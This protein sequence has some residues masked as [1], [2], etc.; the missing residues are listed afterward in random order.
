MSAVHVCSRPGKL[1]ATPN[2]IVLVWYLKRTNMKS[3]SPSTSCE[4]HRVCCESDPPAHLTKDG[5]NRLQYK[6]SVAPPVGQASLPVAQA[7]Q[8]VEAEGDLNSYPPVYSAI[9]QRHLSTTRGHNSRR[10]FSLILLIL[11]LSSLVAVLGFVAERRGARLQHAATNITSIPPSLVA[12]GTTP[13]LLHQ[14]RLQSQASAGDRFG[15]SVA[16]DGNWLAVGTYRRRVGNFTSCG[17]V[18]LFQNE[19]GIWHERQTVVPGD[20]HENLRFGRSVALHE[21]T[22]AVGAYFDDHAGPYAGS[23][24]V[25]QLTKNT[26]AEP[27]WELEAKLIANDASPHAIFGT[28]LVLLGNNNLFVTAKNEDNETGSVYFFQKAEDRKWNQR[29]KI[30]AS[31][32]APSNRFGTSI[33]VS[34]SLLVV[35]ADKGDSSELFAGSVHVFTVSSDGLWTE[36]QRLE[37]QDTIIGD[38]FGFSVAVGHDVIVVGA[39][40]DADQGTNSGSVYVFSKSDHDGGVWRQQQKLRASSSATTTRLFGFSLATNGEYLIV[41]AKVGVDG[42]SA[43]SGYVFSRDETLGAWTENFVMGIDDPDGKG[44]VPKIAV[45]DDTIVV[46]SAYSN[47]PD[48]RDAGD[49]FVYRL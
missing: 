35:G 42:S 1:L 23:A 47:T 7:I 6:H 28:D 11:A 17:S 30:R 4:G 21:Q 43:G 33:A 26:T 32:A 29:Q 40:S 14:S 15:I 31:N 8:I 39:I 10:H 38:S 2:V 9:A 22:L 18:V 12:Q 44:L 27:S 36:S 41:G 19:R 13:M 34:D 45:S 37:G 20:C 24:Y 46:G 49:V 48:G 3:E 25:F 16:L 5:P